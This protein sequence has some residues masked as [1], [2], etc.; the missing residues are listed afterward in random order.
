[1]VVERQFATMDDYLEAIRPGIDA[2]QSELDAFRGQGGEI[3]HMVNAVDQAVKAALEGCYGIGAVLVNNANGEVA[4]MGRNRVND[5]NHPWR[6]VSHAEMDA[7][8]MFNRQYVAG[9]NYMP[10]PNGRPYSVYSTLQPCPMCSTV[11]TRTGVLDARFGVEDG[12]GAWEVDG[13]G[14]FTSL[15]SLPPEVGRIFV[16]SVAN[17][18]LAEIPSELSTL[19]D[20]IFQ[21]TRE[22][23]DGLLVESMTRDEREPVE[24]DHEEF[25]GQALVWAKHAAREGNY[26]IGAVIV[27]R[28]GRTVASGIN[29]LLERQNV[30]RHIAYAEPFAMAVMNEQITA[31][32]NTSAPFE[33]PYT[34]FTT[35]QPNIPVMCI[36]MTGRLKR[37][38]YAVEDSR[39]S[40]KPEDVLTTGWNSIYR[41]GGYQ[42]EQSREIS[43]ALRDECQA[44]FEEGRERLDRDITARL[45]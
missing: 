6:H 27:D 35:V 10:I 13:E 45:L 37:M 17:H 31:A 21:A 16:D 5:D 40:G 8:A 25:M 28:N 18:R 43:S 2:I 33:G 44:V 12:W 24:L 23:V 20:R 19:C 38:F 4:A 36:G 9:H 15:R 34:C 29:N 1:M 7:L 41:D 39:A 30:Y 3:D 26:G 22:Q 11:L 32:S 42:Y 14:K